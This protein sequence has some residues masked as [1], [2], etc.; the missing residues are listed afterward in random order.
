[1]SGANTPQAVEADRPPLSPPPSAY[2]LS[3]V[4][5]LDVRGVPGYG[6]EPDLPSERDNCSLIWTFDIDGKAVI[7]G[8]ISR[9]SIGNRASRAALSDSLHNLIRC[10]SLA[11]EGRLL[12]AR[13]VTRDYLRAEPP[14]FAPRLQ[15]AYGLRERRPQAREVQPRR[16]HR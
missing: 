6:A 16:E 11:V 9:R 14:I 1:M 12:L 5:P 3:P 13:A 2:Q 8:R 10:P 15:V 7:V 4:R